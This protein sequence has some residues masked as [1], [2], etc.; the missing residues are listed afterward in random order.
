M[1]A[2]GDCIFCR[3][4]RGDAPAS[5]VAQDDNILAFLD[6]RPINVG[7]TLVVPRRHASLLADLQ[8]AMGRAIFEMAQRVAA[9][10]RASGLRCEGVN[11]HLADGE[12]AG[13]EVFHV[14]LHVYPRFA[15]DGVGLRFGPK[16]GTTPPR[17]ELD[18]TATRIRGALGTSAQAE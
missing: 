17:S 5:V 3:I 10:L 7:H 1:A 6:I 13:Q 12:V 11:F 8:P 15:G 9:G 2:S 14:H 4:V 18:R 16:Y